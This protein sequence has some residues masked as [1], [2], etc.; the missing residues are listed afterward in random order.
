[1][2]KTFYEKLVTGKKLDSG[3]GRKSLCGKDRGSRGM[4]SAPP[5]LSL[6]SY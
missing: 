2:N 5:P 3:T 4:P 1:M 6:K